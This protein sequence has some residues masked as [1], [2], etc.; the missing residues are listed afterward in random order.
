MQATWSTVG[1]AYL[2]TKLDS[3]LIS[4]GKGNVSGQSHR[5]AF[6]ILAAA[7]EWANG[8]QSPG[9]GLGLQGFG[10]L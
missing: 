10:Q 3:K 1:T 9:K 8:T 7:R 4:Y 6:N 2:G 5:Y